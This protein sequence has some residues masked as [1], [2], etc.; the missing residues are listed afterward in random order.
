ML[1]NVWL[2]IIIAMCRTSRPYDEEVF[3]RARSR[4]FPAA[5]A[6]VCG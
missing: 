6:I 1:G 2:R 4:H 5:V 3:L